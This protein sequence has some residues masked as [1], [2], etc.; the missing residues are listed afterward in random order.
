VA[1][2]RPAYTSSSETARQLDRELDAELAL[3]E[4]E[5]NWLNITGAELLTAASNDEVRAEVAAKIQ[6]VQDAWNQLQL[7]RKNRS[8]KLSEIQQ[9]TPNFHNL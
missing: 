8:S 4:R 3:K 2:S 5:L 1:H 7:S 9:V 6:W